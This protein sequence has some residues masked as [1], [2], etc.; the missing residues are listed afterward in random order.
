MTERIIHHLFNSNRHAHV[1]PFEIVYYAYDS[2]LLRCTVLP[3]LW[4][5]FAWLLGGYLTFLRTLPEAVLDKLNSNFLISHSIARLIQSFHKLLCAKR[6]NHHHLDKWK[7]HLSSVWIH[8]D[9]DTHIP[10]KK[11]VLIESWF[12][13]ITLYCASILWKVF[14]WLL[15]A[16]LTL[17]RSVLEAVLQKLISNFH[18]HLDKRESHLFVQCTSTRTR[19]SLWHD[20]VPI[21]SWF[22]YMALYRASCTNHHHL[23]KWK[24][25]LFVFQCTSAHTRT[26]I[27]FPGS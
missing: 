25:H 23:D 22:M 5:V 15:E 19:T 17:L 20:V 1:L 6:L 11:S 9:N 18:H 3:V 7:H 14:A 2:C 13:F 27:C 26:S 10:F 8:I 12:M 24:R 21:K 16:Y 4:Q